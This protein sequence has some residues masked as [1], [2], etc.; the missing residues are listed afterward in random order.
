MRSEMVGTRWLSTTSSFRPFA[1]WR[2]HRPR[3]LHLQDFIGDRRVIQLDHACHRLRLLPLRRLRR[4]N[5]SGNDGQ[6]G[7]NGGY[8]IR[9]VMGCLLNSAWR[10]RAAPRLPAAAGW[11]T[12][13]TRLAVRQ[14]RLGRLL[15]V[16]RGHREPLF[17]LG[18]DAIGI[19]IRAV[20]VRQRDG[21]GEHALAREQRL[22]RVAVLRPLQFLFGNRRETRRRSL[23]RSGPPLPPGS[24]R[25]GRRRDLQ[26]RR[27]GPAIHE[28]ERFGWPA[29]S[30]SPASDTAA[31]FRRRPESARRPRARG[32]RESPVAGIR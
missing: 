21:R 27:P 14:V 30:P 6:N 13:T 17:R 8:R 29:P 16:R 32:H 3:Q 9:F 1:S 28:R 20:I 2:L 11:V 12:I 24:C 26:F 10:A 5:R 25:A 23:R 15:D 31:S 19:V 4:G 22:R 7:H 18:V